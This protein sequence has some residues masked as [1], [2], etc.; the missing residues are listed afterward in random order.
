MASP[1]VSEDSEDPVILRPHIV[2]KINRPYMS[3][4]RYMYKRQ[5]RIMNF[6]IKWVQVMEELNWRLKSVSK[7]SLQLVCL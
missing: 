3:R 2:N 6:N 4:T 7:L 5:A 1:E